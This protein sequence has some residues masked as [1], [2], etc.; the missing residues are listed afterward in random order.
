MFLSCTL[1]TISSRGTAQGE[2]FSPYVDSLRNK[3]AWGQKLVRMRP[4]AH[5]TMTDSGTKG[6]DGKG[7]GRKKEMGNQEQKTAK[8]NKSVQE[9]ITITPRECKVYKG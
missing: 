6:W 3:N 1:G 7:T 4:C 5:E 9:D 8:D 2:L